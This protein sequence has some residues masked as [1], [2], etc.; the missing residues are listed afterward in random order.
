M[1]VESLVE[2]DLAIVLSGFFAPLLA[3]DDK[4][5]QVFPRPRPATC[6]WFEFSL[7]L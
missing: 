6:V 4:M 7:V 3:T 5:E 2:T 1:D